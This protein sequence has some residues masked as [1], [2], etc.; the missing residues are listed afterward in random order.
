MNTDA[1]TPLLSDDLLVEH[2]SARH[3]PLRL[4]VVTE[5]YPPEINGVARTLARLVHSLQD[6]G[7]DVQLIRPRQPPDGRHITQQEPL[8]QILVRGL[9]IPRYPHLRMGLPAKN[10]LVK[11][12]SLQRPDVV[13]IATQ[14]PLGWSALQA[15]RKLRLPISTDFRTN[16]DA[17]SKHY[18]IAWLQRPIAAYL[19]KFHNLA[20]CTTVPTE[21]LRA[22]LVANRFERLKVIAR[23]VDVA[24]FN[25]SFRDAALRASW[26]AGEQDCVALYVGRLAAE[27]NL[28]L[29]ARAF[30]SMKAAN[31]RVRLVVVGDGPAREE[32]QANCFDAKLCG[33]QSGQALARHYAS[34]DCFV[35]PSLT[36]TYGNVTPEAL[37]SGLAVLAFDHAAASDLIC[38]GR[39]GLLAPVGDEASFLRMAVHLATDP[40]LIQQVRQQ[41]VT[42]VA[43]RSWSQIASQV[44]TMW[45]DLLKSRL[46]SHP[47]KYARTPVSFA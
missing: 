14:G 9:P 38:S 4:A 23:G 12:W 37:A 24:S 20:D 26:G 16:F 35:F 13:H 41:A 33:S 15:A 18:G 27:K 34:A 19:R 36:E 47:E 11:H 6:L 46:G 21:A 1:P 31:P 30:Q 29:L 39:N 2:L 40:T 5:T 3:P 10:A 17:Y 28:G 44:E 7:H 42:A 25:P 8:E 22:A 45:I 43:E 32:L